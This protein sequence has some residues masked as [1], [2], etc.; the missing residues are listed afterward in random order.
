MFLYLLAV[1]GVMVYAHYCGGS[2]E[3]WAVYLKGGGCEDGDCGDEEQQ[4]DACCNDK[5]VTSKVSQDQH[6]TDG[7]KLKLSNLMPDIPPVQHS[8]DQRET[9]YFDTSAKF[10]TRANAPPGL[11]EDIP[12][13]K[14]HSSFTYYG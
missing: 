11:W 14:L 10:T 5:I 8:F 2:L 6:M 12:L 7:L 1:S 9:N 13:Y 3:S 4:S